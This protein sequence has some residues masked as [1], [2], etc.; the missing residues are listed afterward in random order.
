MQ[1]F[2]ITAMAT[3]TAA[4]AA[5]A[6]LADTGTH[7]HPH[8]SDPAWPL[9]TLGMLTLAAAAWLIWGGK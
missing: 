5:N 8:A 6:A 9:L 1:R 3:S 7:M 4:I 2:A